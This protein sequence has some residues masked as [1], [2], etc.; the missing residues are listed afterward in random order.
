VFSSVFLVRDGKRTGIGG[1]RDRWSDLD[2]EAAFG[3]RV[4]SRAG[5]GEGKMAYIYQGIMPVRK[6]PHDVGIDQKPEII[7]C[8]GL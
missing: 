7:L 2:A 6:I 5:A 4:S 3:W 8:S 1:R